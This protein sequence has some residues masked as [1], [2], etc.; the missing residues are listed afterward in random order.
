MPPFKRHAFTLAELMVVI[1]I[2]FLLLALVLPATRRVRGAA[3]KMQCASNMR[4]L[5][6]ATHNYQNDHNALPPGCISA[7]TNAESRL[8][9]MVAVL[10]YM[11]QDK[12]FK[13]IDI[14]K[15][16]DGN[17]P[18]ITTKLK[19]LHCPAVAT[20]LNESVTHYVAMSGIGKEAAGQPVG[21]AGNGFMGYDRIT[22]LGMIFVKDG[23]SNT[24]ALIETGF[25]PG[26]WAR[27]G[28]ATLRGFDP[29]FHPWAGEQRPFGG[30]HYKTN[31]AFVDG[32]VRGQTNT[33]DPKTLAAAITIAGGENI[34]WSDWE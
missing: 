4:Q 2:I 32:S 27:G 15:G 18:A 13:S 30:F 26:P 8:S 1:A 19:N 17:Y 21:A 31:V 23:T 11:E 3:E 33:Q 9:W 25:E 5:V 29:T 6:I 22:T 20:P 14:S 12:L 10:P 16:F 34:N 28:V 24:I 7:G